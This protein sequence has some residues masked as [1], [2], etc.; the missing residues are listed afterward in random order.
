MAAGDL[1]VSMEAGKRDDLGEVQHALNQL[2]ANLSA[3]V[4]DVRG[5]IGG[6]MDAAREISSGNMDLSRR[7]ELQAAS[8]EQTAATMDQL[9]STVTGNAD[10]SVRALELVKEAQTAASDG[11]KIAV[12]VEETMAGINT[13]S[14]RIADITGVI[15]G[16]A[17]QT[18][19]L[20]L[21]AAVE[22]AR[23]GEAGRSFAV[24]AT[25]VRNLAQRCAASAREIKVVV[26]TSV[27]QIA[28]GTDLV[29][30][31]TS[32]MRA[33]DAAVHRVSA[34]ISEVANASSEQ[35]EG[36]RQVNQAVAHLDGSTQ[37]NAALVEQAAATA[38]R[39]AER[40][41][42]LDEAVRLF[43]V[44]GAAKVAV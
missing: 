10:A 23:A 16:I 1:T 31:T 3:I 28:E 44:E 18:N 35:A 14:Q 19:I 41:D 5:Q 36:I 40:A 27:A 24:V 29:S 39:L 2:K 34:I 22:A 8:L 33:I 12:R 13:A 37:E 30:R 17:F 20:A 38:L 26:E 11:G 7:T 4:L 9:T 43:T 25:E 15:D 32:Q 42:V 6:M 21:N